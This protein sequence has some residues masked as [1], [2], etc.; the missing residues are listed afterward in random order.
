[1]PEI[2]ARYASDD[3]LLFRLL[4]IAMN[5]FDAKC[6]EYI[7]RVLS[8]DDTKLRSLL[9]SPCKEPPEGKFASG[10]YSELAVVYTGIMN[11]ES[12]DSITDTLMAFEIENSAI[13]EN[14]DG[15]LSKL[16]GSTKYLETL[17]GDIDKDKD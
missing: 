15:D 2:Q 10:A 7:T 12:E 8:V 5:N 3:E 9:E 17:F 14:W 13:L 16:E 4:Y 6:W 11:Q 1:M